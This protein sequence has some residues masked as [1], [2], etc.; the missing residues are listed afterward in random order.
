MICEFCNKE[1]KNVGGYV[2]HKNQ[3]EKT[4]HLK[5]KVINLYL[6]E[7]KSIKE[8][9]VITGLCKNKICEYLKEIKRNQ[10]E[11]SKIAHEKFPNSFKHSDETK[12]KI[13]EKHL[14]W[15][16]NNPEKTAW[17]TSNFSYPEKLLFNKFIE[18]KWDE[19]Y[20][21]IREK[22]VFPYFLD[23]AFENEKVDVE[24]DGSQHLLPERKESDEKR[25]RMLI[26]NGW[27]IIRISENEVK[28]NI[29]NCI[30]II[31]NTIINRETSNLSKLQKIGIFKEVKKY[32]KK[33]RNENGLTDNQIQGILNQRK[34]ER[35][36][37][38]IL[39]KEIEKSGYVSVGR[40]YNV[41]DNSI[42]KWIKFY[43]ARFI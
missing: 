43:E 30:N 13:R 32:I 27:V 31:Q 20:L 25:D 4:I 11:S 15:M 35:P 1:I 10:S 42:R 38:D 24:V 6:N 21:I 26:D 14:E 12:R 8:I 41:S 34:T 37:Y 2:S 23:F 16:K 3:C 22:S 7:Y 9:N 29:E 5:Y 18:L 36:P 28:N 33:E 19:K 17:R 39:I 40:K